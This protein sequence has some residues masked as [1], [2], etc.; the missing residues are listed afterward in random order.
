LTP[1]SLSLLATSAP[2]AGSSGGLVTRKGYR[3]PC[4]RRGSR[5]GGGTY[6]VNAPAR[7]RAL[8]PSALLDRARPPSSPK[9]Q[10]VAAK[11]TPRS[12]KASSRRSERVWI[13]KA[14][15]ASARRRSVRTASDRGQCDHGLRHR[16]NA[17]RPPRRRGDREHAHACPR[18][19]AFATC[20]TLREWT[21]N[22]ERAFRYLAVCTDE[23]VVDEDAV[24]SR[25]SELPEHGRD[26]AVPSRVVE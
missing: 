8:E 5:G 1:K 9:R 7:T 24:V 22:A 2:R 13:G 4:L 19:L 25:T 3:C 20:P 14:F 26:D 15:L 11:S 21:A 23:T 18:P 17:R 16:Q 10:S 6:P 12:Q